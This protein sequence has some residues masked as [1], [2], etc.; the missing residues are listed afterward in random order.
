MLK[1]LLVAVA[2]LIASI[3]VAFAAVNINTASQAE[4]EG[5]KG[6]GPS[7]AKAIVDYRTKS[8]NFKTIEDLKNVKGIGDKTF[9]K[10]KGD[11][12][13][14]GATTAAAA[15]PKKVEKAPAKK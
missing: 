13:V 3:G 9:E 11:L 6:I 14:S 15:D 2:A 1:K 12:T 4:L 8:G 5:L 7:K 10:L